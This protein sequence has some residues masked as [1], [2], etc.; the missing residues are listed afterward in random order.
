MAAYDRDLVSPMPTRAVVLAAALAVV[1]CPERGAGD[2]GAKNMANL[3]ASSVLGWALKIERSGEVF[4][5]EAARRARDRDVQLLFE[6]LGHQE[7]RHYRTFERLLGQVPASAQAS[8]DPAEYEAYLGATLE[9]ALL[10][11]P[12]K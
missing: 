1:C 3:S 10:G 11:D 6:D 7:E 2:A 5:R 12:D 8:V 4:Y 9:H